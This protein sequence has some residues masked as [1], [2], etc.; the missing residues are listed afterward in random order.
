ML[1]YWSLVVRFRK[2]PVI[3]VLPTIVTRLC[4]IRL[5]ASIMLSSI[6]VAVIAP[7]NTMAQMI[8]QTVLII[9]LIPRVEISALSVFSPV[10]TDVASYI[11]IIN[12]RNRLEIPPS[13]AIWYKM[14]R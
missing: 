5:I 1:R 6:C 8:S 10:S 13:P 12:P 2:T 3:A 9:P 4:A 14:P 11:E 7:P